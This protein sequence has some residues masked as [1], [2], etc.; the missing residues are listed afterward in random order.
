[1][2]DSLDLVK[3]IAIVALTAYEIR[4]LFGAKSAQTPK[5]QGDLKLYEIKW[6]M[7]AVAYASAA[8]W[9][10]FAFYGLRDDV[11]SHGR[12]PLD[13]LLLALGLISLWFGSGVVTT[14]QTGITKTSCWHSASLRWD[15]IAEVRLHKRDGGAIELRGNSRKLIVDSRFVAP[16]YLQN[17]IAERTKLQPLRD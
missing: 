7:R 15:E 4:W 13:L 16:A 5:I 17:E 3:R 10:G 2:T 6:Q 8:L 9:F 12:W 14:D 1:M 11:A